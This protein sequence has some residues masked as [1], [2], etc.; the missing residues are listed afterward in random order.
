MKNLNKVIFIISLLILVGDILS[1]IYTKSMSMEKNSGYEGFK[2]IILSDTTNTF[3]E[4]FDSVYTY[5]DGKCMA[6]TFKLNH[7]CNE[8]NL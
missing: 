3:H 4:D 6:Y 1:L 8:R 7:I 2:P 5:D